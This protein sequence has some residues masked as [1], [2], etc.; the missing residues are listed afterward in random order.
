MDVDRAQDTVTKGLT[1]LP[2][3]RTGK[4]TGVTV[5]TDLSVKNEVSPVHA[6]IYGPPQR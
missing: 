4:G 1:L 3:V 6:V 5:I 2:A